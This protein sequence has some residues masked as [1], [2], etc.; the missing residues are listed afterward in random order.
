[1]NISARHIG[2][3]IELTVTDGNAKITT[4][5]LDSKEALELAEEMISVTSELLGVV[6][7]SNK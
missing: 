3:S 6:R 4:G 5:L 7:E 2:D 1:M